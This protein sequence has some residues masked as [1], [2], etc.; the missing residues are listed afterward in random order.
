[1]SKS[2]RNTP[3]LSVPLQ[4]APY[5]PNKESSGY[6]AKQLN[7]IFRLLVLHHLQSAHRPFAGRERVGFD[8]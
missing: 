3:L 4:L 1:M 5:R 6:L 7:D 8:P 2:R